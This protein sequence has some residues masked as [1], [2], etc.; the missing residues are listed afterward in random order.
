MYYKYNKPKC[1]NF[2]NILIFFL[3]FL[4]LFFA[5]KINFL[6]VKQQKTSLLKTGFEELKKNTHRLQN[7]GGLDA[8][9]E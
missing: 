5:K 9:N 4:C 2:H 8:T 6:L 7:F 3:S 1:V